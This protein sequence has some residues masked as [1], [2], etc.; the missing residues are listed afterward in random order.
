MLQSLFCQLNDNLIFHKP[1]VD[2]DL[3]TNVSQIAIIVKG[4]LSALT[5]AYTQDTFKFMLRTIPL[6][7]QSLI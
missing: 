5:L 6:L 3:F 7:V 4:P 1:S 2:L